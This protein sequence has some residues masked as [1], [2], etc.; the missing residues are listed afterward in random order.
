MARINDT[1]AAASAST[2]TANSV[3][4]LDLDVFLKIMLQELQNQDPLDPMDNAQL[5]QQL[6]QIRE[7]SSNDKLTGTLDSVLLGQNVATATGLIGTEVEGITDSGQRASG[8][9]QRVTINDGQPVLDLAV[10]TRA[11][12]GDTEGQIDTGRYTY[13]V[14][15]ETDDAVFSVQ[16]QVDTAELGEDFE[17]SIRVENLPETSVSKRVYRT[18]KSGS[19]EQRLVGVLASGSST[20]FTDTLADNQRQAEVLTGSRQVLQFASAVKVK[21]SNI[22][23]VRTLQ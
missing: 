20:T 18:D 13:E 23:Q 21:L 11:K 5:L 14:V 22:N 17:G 19:G 10:A 2:P 16:T 6:S 3:Q 4:N 1:T 15:W 8:P 12:A 7:I 9:V